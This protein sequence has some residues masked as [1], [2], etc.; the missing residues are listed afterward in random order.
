MHRKPTQTFGHI[1]FSKD[2]KV[3]KHL[4]RLS[5]DKQIQEMEALHKFL[6]LFNTVFPER[7]ITFLRQLEERDHDFIVDVA[8]QETEIQLTELVDR[9]FTFQMTQAEYDSGNWSHAVQK[10]YGE[11]PWRIDPEKRD[12]A[13]VE[14]I[15]R[16]ISKSYSKSL[17]RPLWLIVFATFIYE[18]E[19]SQGGKLRVSQGLQKARD[20]LSTETRNVFDAVWVTDLETRPVCVWSR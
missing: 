19:F 7:S 5:E 4:T 20:Y 6:E 18:T 3:A 17:V 2:G 10:G 8:G 16:K 11:L 15:E 13:L 1:T 12:L 9:S 14:L